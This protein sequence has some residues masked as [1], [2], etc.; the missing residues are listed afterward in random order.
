MIVRETGGPTKGGGGPAP[1]D[2]TTGVKTTIALDDMVSSWFLLCDEGRVVAWSPDLPSLLGRERLTRRFEAVEMFHDEDQ[3]RVA[4]ALRGA[5]SEPPTP[6][7]P[8]ELSVSTADGPRRMACVFTP[9]RG[10]GPRLLC[11]LLPLPG[12]E[13]RSRKGRVPELTARQQ[14]VLRLIVDGYST[15]EIAS[16]LGL[17]PHT[18]RNHVRALLARLG[19][20]SKLEAV[21]LAFRRGLL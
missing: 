14:Q 13:E 21:V 6:L 7:P 12:S 10:R 16:R 17:R 1:R 8:Q 9:L 19:V 15:E 5:R 20:R 2:P 3:R 4:Q 18:V 11:Q